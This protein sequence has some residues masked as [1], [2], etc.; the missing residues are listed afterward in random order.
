MAS[1]NNG[2]NWDGSEAAVDGT[3]RKKESTTNCIKTELVLLLSFKLYS[4]PLSVDVKLF[5]LLCIL[6]V[7][8]MSF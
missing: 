3:I 4:L 7:I 6:F 1:G 8:F 5:I 2:S